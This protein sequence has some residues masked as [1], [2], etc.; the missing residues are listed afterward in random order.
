MRGE[1]HVLLHLLEGPHY[2]QGILCNV[3]VHAFSL[4]AVAWYFTGV[5]YTNAVTFSDGSSVRLVR[6][7]RPHLAFA[8]RTNLTPV[9]L[10][11]SAVWPNSG[12]RSFTLVQAVG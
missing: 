2:C 10:I 8:S 6:R 4:D 11:N 1:F 12:D 5:A 7:E 3:G 9:A